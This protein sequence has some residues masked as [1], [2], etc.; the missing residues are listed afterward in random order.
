MIA[1]RN[2]HV[3]V[4]AT[5]PEPKF[6]LSIDWKTGRASFGEIT[7][8]RDGDKIVANFPDVGGMAL[9][10]SVKR[11]TGGAVLVESEDK[12][13]KLFLGGETLKLVRIEPLSAPAGSAEDVKQK[14]TADKAAAASATRLPSAHELS[15]SAGI[16]WSKGA[17]PMF[18]AGWRFLFRPLGEFIRF[19]LAVQLDYLPGA[20][21]GTAG[22]GIGVEGQLPTSVPLTLS[23]HG[24]LKG[25]VVAPSGDKPL[26]VFGPS[27][28]L[29]AG[30][31]VTK[32]LNVHIDGGYMF[33]MLDAAQKS[34]V[35]DVPSLTV[36]ATLR[37]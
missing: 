23:L 35:K 26:P 4:E 34:G 1:A 36:G 21:L 10:L 25:G 14:Q 13:V 18:S 28:G 16:G 20:Q 31:N 30:V 8:K 6:D 9:D 15:A 12:L 2:I 19:P 24:G 37:L 33:N 17:H 32:G 29:E 7:A 27:F 5:S 22:I 11:Q 3:R